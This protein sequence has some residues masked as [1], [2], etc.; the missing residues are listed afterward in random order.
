MSRGHG[1]ACV[2]SRA[3]SFCQWPFAIRYKATLSGSSTAMCDGPE[4]SSRT[5]TSR[6]RSSCAQRGI[7]RTVRGAASRANAEESDR[8]MDTITIENSPAPCW[9]CAIQTKLWRF[10]ESETCTD[11]AACSGFTVRAPRDSSCTRKPW[12]ISS[13]SFVLREDLFATMREIAPGPVA[14]TIFRANSCSVP[15]QSVAE[16]TMGVRKE[17]TKRRQGIQRKARGERL[18]ILG[19][20][21]L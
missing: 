10:S 15:V 21:E 9:I 8:G 13:V 19:M 20:G 11:A 18:G 5:A 2:I 14:A 3:C 7:L 12:L 16:L 1:C 4:V 6:I 17:I